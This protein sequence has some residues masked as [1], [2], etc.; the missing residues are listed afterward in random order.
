VGERGKKERGERGEGERPNLVPY[1]YRTGVRH[2]WLHFLPTCKADLVVEC[3]F[4]CAMRMIPV[5]LSTRR[6]KKSQRSIIS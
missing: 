4:N 5:S 1:K 6:A 3:L 2:G